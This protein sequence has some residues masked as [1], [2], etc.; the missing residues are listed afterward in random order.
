[1]LE[2]DAV[3]STSR[4]A[5]ASF[6][7]IDDAT[8]LIVSDCSLFRSGLAT[9]LSGWP[10]ASV[11]TAK[12]ADAGRLNGGDWDIVLL[13]VSPGMEAEEQLQQAL[14]F[15]GT[16]CVVVTDRFSF[17]VYAASLKVNAYG[18]LM[19]DI[20]ISALQVALMLVLNGKKVFP[21]Q[22]ALSRFS[23][24]R[25]NDRSPAPAI[26]SAPRRNMR[27]S[28]QQIRILDYLVQGDSNKM[29]ARRLGNT[30]ATVK[31]QMKA[32]LRKLGLQNRTQAAVWAV[33]NGFGSVSAM[34]ES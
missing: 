24:M 13:D 22:L 19:K 34:S 4:P 6:D 31:V 16:P 7:E 15:P 8:L 20:S 11:D 27:F 32:L 5:D 2:A 18:Y 10:F 1:M 9:A 29:I 26:K 25:Y 12:N 23:T 33:T 17:D 21:T 30:E 3:A 28:G 14:C